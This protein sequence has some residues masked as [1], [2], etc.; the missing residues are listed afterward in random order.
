[1]FNYELMASGAFRAEIPRWSCR[2]AAPMAGRPDVDETNEIGT[3]RMI[4]YR[5]R[6]E[7]DLKRWQEAGWLT[8]DG[9]RAIQADIASRGSRFGL[10]Q[11]LALLGGVL[12]CFGAMTF[13]ASNWQAMSKLARLA[14]LAVGLWGSFGA[15]FAFF[16]RGQ[17]AFG[18]TAVLVGS[19]V[20]GAAIMLISQMYHVDGHPPDAVLVWGIGAAL[21]GVVLRSNPALVLA[22]LLLGLWSAWESNL[23]QA[24]HWAFLPAW[25]ALTA[26]S[27]A[28]TRWRPLYHVLVLMLAGWVTLLGVYWYGP[29]WF[30]LG[31]QQAP[32]FVTA[33]VG[34]GLAGLIAAARPWI[35]RVVPIGQAATAYLL[36]ASFIGLWALQFIQRSRV[37]LPLGV[38]FVLALAALIGTI[39]YALRAGNRPVLWLAYVAF[40]IELVSIYFKTLGTLLNTSLFFLSAGLLVIGLSWIAWK[41][42]NRAPA[43]TG[44]QS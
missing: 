43:L 33:L 1:M 39:V 14:V 37:D 16:R 17:D 22:V 32:F 3:Q 44:G 12:L 42:H 36:G 23:V 40:S 4:G 38:W 7:T 2:S 19:G 8:G 25:A 24:V 34:L 18:H 5:A 10:P 31:T 20:F 35:D 29:V 30:Q 13:V 11:V 9:A 28:V 26:S 21:A 15:A 41:L 27:L 6:I